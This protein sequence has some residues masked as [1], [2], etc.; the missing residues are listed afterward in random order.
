MK[1]RFHRALPIAALLSAALLAACTTTPGLRYDRDPS[2]DFEAF[3][4]FAFY[5]QPSAEALPYK[6]LVDRRLLQATR[7]QLERQGYV[8]SESEPDLRV[9]LFVKVSEKIEL[10]SSAP[11]RGLYGHRRWSSDLETRPYR[12]GTLCVDLVDAKRHVLVWQGVAEGRLGAAATQDPG[13]V[14]ER[15]V[16]EV[17]A[18]L[19]AATRAATP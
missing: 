15:T 4:T 14:A 2:A 11:S 9:N 12:E 3:R 8:Y 17:L 10:R 1:A 7:E 16:R 19:P 6:S 13:A 5:E 18:A